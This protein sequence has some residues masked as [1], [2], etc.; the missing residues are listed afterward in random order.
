MEKVK[1]FLVSNQHRQFYVLNIKRIPSKE[2]SELVKKLRKVISSS[3][4]EEYEDNLFG[5]GINHKNYVLNTVIFNRFFKFDLYPLSVAT[6]LMVEDLFKI[7]RFQGCDFTLCYDQKEK[8]HTLWFEYY[9]SSNDFWSVS[10][11]RKCV[12]VTNNY[13]N[14]VAIQNKLS[15]LVHRPIDLKTLKS[16]C[17]ELEYWINYIFNNSEKSYRITEID[18]NGFFHRLH[19]KYKNNIYDFYE[20]KHFLNNFVYKKEIYF[21][22]AIKRAYS[23]DS[24]PQTIKLNDVIGLEDAKKAINEKII[25]PFLHEGVFRKYKKKTGGGILLFGLPGNGKT[26]LAK[27]VASE[28]GLPFF[29]MTPSSIKNKTPGK[30]EKE[31]KKIFA[32][33][34]KEKRAVIFI[35]EIDSIAPRRNAKAASLLENSLVTTLLEEM[36]GLK[37]RKED[38]CILV[39]GA[40]NRPEDIDSALLRTGRID[41]KIYVGLPNFKDRVQMFELFLKDIFD[42]TKDL[43]IEILAEKTKGFNGADIKEYVES[44]KLILIKKDIQES[45]EIKIT[46]DESLELLEDFSPTVNKD[47]LEHFQNKY[48]VGNNNEKN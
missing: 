40:T 23:K 43:D 35:D 16:F 44:L 21:A 17:I 7:N 46:N 37:Q 20:P 12:F 18:K 27:A 32:N 10:K 26:L 6:R 38:E 29:K 22:N 24:K 34:R 45:S 15:E 11:K 48:E 33:A 28:L 5:N 8:I 36:D 14:L 39:I 31:I 47:D 19:F 1:N 3:G 2:Y 42:F 4:I 13:S 9:E 25:K 41:T 30:S